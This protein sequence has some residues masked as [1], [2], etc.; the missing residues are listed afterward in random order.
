LGSKLN[1]DL[2]CN[3]VI[4]AKKGVIHPRAFNSLALGICSATCVQCGVEADNVASF[5]FYHRPIEALQTL[6]DFAERSN[7]GCHFISLP[8]SLLLDQVCP[9]VVPRSVCAKCDISEGTI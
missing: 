3:G 8:C 4:H 7:F 5:Q 1:R 9:Q 2:L 6:G